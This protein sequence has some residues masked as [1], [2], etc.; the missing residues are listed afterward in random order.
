MARN[1]FEDVHHNMIMTLLYNFPIDHVNDNGIKFWTSPKRPPHAIQYDDKD[2]IIQNFI[3][4]SANI[5]AFIFN[6]PKISKEEAAKGSNS[7]NVD[8]F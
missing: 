6:L 5:F 3:W 7:M 4:A 2:E 1:M 8:K